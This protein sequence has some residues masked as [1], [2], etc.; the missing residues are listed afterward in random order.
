MRAEFR[1]RLRRRLRSAITP[2]TSGQPAAELH[3]PVLHFLVA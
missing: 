3:D 2:A 1:L